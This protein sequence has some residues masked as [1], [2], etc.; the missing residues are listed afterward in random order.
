MVPDTFEHDVPHGGLQRLS[1]WRDKAA[2]Q[3]VRVQD[4][5]TAH[6]PAEEIAAAADRF[7]IGLIVRARAA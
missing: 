4:H 1:E 5:I 2:A 3:G 6:F 7:R